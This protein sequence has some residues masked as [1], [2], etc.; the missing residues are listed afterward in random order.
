MSDPEIVVETDPEE[1]FTAL[2]DETRVAILQ[3]LWSPSKDWS[4]REDHG[5]SELREAVGMRD[6][7]QFN[8]HLDKLTGRF[9]RKTDEG[10]Q[11]TLAGRQV[12]GAIRAGS[13]T[14][15][16]SVE[17]LDLDEPCPTCG[18]VLTLQYEDEQVDIACAECNHRL[19]FWIPPGVFEDVAREDFPRVASRYMRASVRKMKAGFCWFC[20]GTMATE[21]VAVDELVPAGAS[22]VSLDGDLPMVRY[23]CTRCG[24][25]VTSDLG[26]AVLDEPEVAAFHESHGIDVVGDDWWHHSVLEPDDAHFGEEGGACVHYHA[27]GETLRVRVDEALDVVETERAAD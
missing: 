27:G 17:P 19:G 23:R 16:G 1:A 10:Y 24:A 20:E 22:E 2:A 12:V 9:V 3:A 18:A 21:L 7:G 8:Y 25:S 15:S 13:Y 4:A 26:T 11:L 6:S 5:F 14:M